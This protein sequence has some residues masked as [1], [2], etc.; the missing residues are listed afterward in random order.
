MYIPKQLSLF[1]SLLLLLVPTAVSAATISLR[2]TPVK[3]GVGDTVL[4]TMVLDSAIP[5]NAFSGTVQYPSTLLEPLTASDGNSIVS[6][7][8]T[9]PTVTD[10]Q[11]QVPF[12]GI[13]PGGF[14]GTRGILFS[15]LFRATASGTA[16]ISV[17][18]SEVLRN[19]GKGSNEPV[20]IQQLS[21]SIEPRS[22]GGYTEP[23]DTT[24]PEPFAAY[25][26]TDPQLLQGKAYLVFS[27]ADK[28]S[29]IDYY[30]V[31]ESRLPSFLFSLLPL[32]WNE[33]TSP[34]ML[35]DQ[36]LTS[37]VYIKAVDRAGNERLSVYP[38]RYLFTAYEMIVLI[39]I[40]IGVVFLYNRRGRGRRFK[41][42]P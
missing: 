29:G 35:V 30:A 37:T 31:A 16:T 5:T 36:N 13:T 22:S 15:V 34:Y 32:S 3:I 19:D 12:A 26:G 28:G 14:S 4:I 9:H 21:L 33:T 17:G 27:A 40:L 2:A 25:L 6:A 41:Q 11:G 24:P 23:A 1:A 20:T 7:W 38:P 42:N 39:A 10:A 18:N 8:I